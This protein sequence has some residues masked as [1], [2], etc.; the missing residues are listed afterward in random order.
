MRTQRLSRLLALSLSVLL[1]SACSSDPPKPDPKKVLELHREMALRYFDQG[2][3]LRSEDQISKGLDIDPKDVQL[4]LMLGW[5]R[6]RRGTKEDILVAER[7]FRDLAPAKD[8]RALL[9]LA[10]SL[11]RKGMLYSEAAGGLERGDVVIDTGDPV[12]LAAQR[13]TEAQ[14]FWKEAVSFYLQTLEKRPDEPQAINGLQRTYA[15]LGN[16]AE[17][18]KWS[19]TLLQQTGLEIEAWNKMLSRS[20]LTARDEERFRNLLKSTTDLEVETHLTASTLLRRL[21]RKA[22]A[23]QHLDQV[24]AMAP[25]RPDGYSR[26]AEL[27]IELGRYDEAMANLDE[28]LRLSTL[29]FEHPDIRRAY[30]LRSD[31]EAAV[32]RTATT[33]R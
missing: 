29:P 5:C 11:E 26:R 4:K 6:Q 28:F 17:S 21:G 19:T 8:Y 25:Q 10:E 3:L 23:V 2:D 13:R 15:L 16:D 33:A 27:L 30:Q 1:A 32:K 22:E 31:C 14:G 20:D 12:A 9:G 24:L 7:V 18:L